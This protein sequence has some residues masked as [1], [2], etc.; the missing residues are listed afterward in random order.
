MVSWKFDA[1]TASGGSRIELSQSAEQAK[2]GLVQ[3]Q[4]MDGA[5][6]DRKSVFFLTETDAANL[7]ESALHSLSLGLSDRKKKG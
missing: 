2:S 4:V 3:I 1:K 7:L 5:H 6:P